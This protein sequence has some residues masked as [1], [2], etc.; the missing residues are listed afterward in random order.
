[1]NKKQI[2]L[3][4]A[5][6]I[7][8]LENKYQLRLTDWREVEIVSE[9]EVPDQAREALQQY[10]AKVE[11]EK[12]AQELVIQV[13]LEQTYKEVVEGMIELYQDL[14]KMKDYRMIYHLFGH[15]ERLVEKAQKLD[16]KRRQD[17]MDNN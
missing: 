11:L 15:V 7:K 1:M 6:H 14:D 2:G 8:R 5:Y 13:G 12:Q 17:A 9:H 4:D 10:T 16:K 3:Q